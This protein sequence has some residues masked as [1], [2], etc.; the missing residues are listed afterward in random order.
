LSQNGYGMPR[1]FRW[2]APKDAPPTGP[3]TEEVERERYFARVL[4]HFAGMTPSGLDDG[5]RAARRAERQ[6]RR[7]QV[8]AQQRFPAGPRQAWTA[9]PGE[10]RGS[11]SSTAS[12]ASSE[13]LRNENWYRGDA[14]RMNYA[15]FEAAAWYLDN[16]GK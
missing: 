14:G 13:E 12:S 11:W 4:L 7:E 9:P 10:R 3:S 2:V 15:Q 1:R 5:S 6:R 16:K 8:E